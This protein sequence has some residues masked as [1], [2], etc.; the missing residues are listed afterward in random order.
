MKHAAPDWVQTLGVVLDGVDVALCLFDHHDCALAWNR[1]FLKLFPE[2]DG[3]LH[4]GEPYQDNLRRFYT[5][6]LGP[7]ELPHIDSYIAAGVARHR[8]Q[9]QPYV[10]E[11]RGRRIQVASLPFGDVGRLRVW[12][13]DHWPAAADAPEPLNL[14]AGPGTPLAASTLLLDRVPDGLMICGRDG[15]I[16]WVNESFVLM[17]DLPERGVA[18]GTTMQTVY[19]SVWSKAGAADSPQCQAGLTTLGDNLRF[20]GAPFELA[21]PGQRFMRVIA[22]PADGRSTFYA[23]VD[24]SE[25]KRQQRL[26]EQAER[27][28]R[29][30]ETT[31]RH[32]S[33]LLLAML[34]NMEQGVA[35]LNADGALNLYNRRA[36]E[37]LRLP[38][39]LSG[40]R[41]GPAG[42]SAYLAAQE[43]FFHALSTLNIEPAPALPGQAAASVQSRCPDGRVIEVR[44]VPVDGG[45]SLRT[46]SDITEHHHE[47]ER[48]RHAATHDSLTG[49][50]NRSM[51]QTCLA[52]ETTIARRT[53]IGCAVLYLDLDGFK[54]IN[55]QHGH[56]VGDRAL[57]WVAQCILRIARESDLAARLGGDEFAVLQKMVT[58][59][60]HAL[61]LGE[62]LLAA[63][64]E[65]FTV[66]TLLLRMGVSIGVSYCPLHADQPEL[67][68][69]C[70]DQAMYSAKAAGRHTVRLFQP[71]LPPA[72]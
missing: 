32:K 25:L 18:L 56:A 46:F 34:E 68:L 52:A 23:H 38:L 54:P 43:A 67:L 60:A 55:D 41:P 40:E 58:D 69:N 20:Y 50:L 29:Q 5:A 47:E 61:A 51:F 4:A 31:L 10:F 44:T 7:D 1:S 30:S 13:A 57:V 12:R 70:A 35:M 8:A 37:L 3:Y 42:S 36:A 49:L 26:L 62:R 53:G 2:H 11:H 28:A 14:S 33:A 15:C 39:P 6:R 48:M 45:G 16:E 64:S 65:S 71:E 17:Y 9:A 63:I 22:R 66:E 72:A 59:P 21:L 27:V 24:I 19:Q